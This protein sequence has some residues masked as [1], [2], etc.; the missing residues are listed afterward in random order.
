MSGM[1][2]DISNTADGSII[3]LQPCAHNPTGL[4]PTELEW[5]E[6]LE[7]IKRKSHF[8]IFDMAYQGLASGDPAADAWPVRFFAKHTPVCVLQRFAENFGLLGDRA[9]CI[10]IVTE[11]EEVSKK[12]SAK[13]A[14]IA[15]PVFGNPSL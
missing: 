13:L 4:D 5:Q 8:T 7:V 1:L 15:K 6:I 2:E 11:S 9:A 3:L 10:S 14:E 12:V